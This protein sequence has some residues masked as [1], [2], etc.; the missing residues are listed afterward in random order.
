M[1]W[2]RCSKTARCNKRLCHNKRRSF[3][4]MLKSG[5]CSSGKI[6]V[7]VIQTRLL[8]RHSKMPS[9]RNVALIL[10]YS[11]CSSMLLVLN[12]LAVTYVPAPSFVLVC[13]LS[14]C[15]AFISC[16][17]RCKVINCETIPKDKLTFFSL[18]V[19]GF[20]GTLFC[21]MSTLKYVPVDTLICFRASMPLVIAV[22]EYFYLGRELPSLRSWLALLGVLSGV[23][24]YT[25]VDIHFSV[26][27]YLWLSV[28]YAFAVSEMVWAKNVVD[29]LKVSS[30]TSSWYQNALSILP[31]ASMAAAAGDHQKLQ[32]VT[33]PSKAGVFVLLSC[34]AGVGMSYFSFALRAEISATSFSVVGN[35][36]KVLTIAVNVLIWDKHA[37]AY[38]LAALMLSLTMGSLYK[39][40]P[41]RQQKAK[42]N[43]FA[44]KDVEKISL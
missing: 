6:K 34:I 14:C 4:L 41:L 1:P 13:Q 40:A 42:D 29:S 31:L 11:A 7:G 2:C 36:C 39:Q 22:V 8:V 44:K 21:N 17:H 33:D 24:L 3:D 26:R 37:N 19:F 32:S 30:W 5:R 27:G 28:W 9:L 20:V 18:I 38:G 16:L 10:C 12:K 15:A 43:V 25:A 35:V 23:C